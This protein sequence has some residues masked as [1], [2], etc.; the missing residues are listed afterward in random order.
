MPYCRQCGRELHLLDQTYA[1]GLC[2][3]CYKEPSRQLGHIDLVHL[4]PKEY[5]SWL[6]A[7]GSEV[8]IL[9]VEVAGVVL[10]QPLIPTLK[11]HNATIESATS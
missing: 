10:M 4:S 1:G 7:H 3:D 11:R 6:R 2:V 9:N 8:E 5:E